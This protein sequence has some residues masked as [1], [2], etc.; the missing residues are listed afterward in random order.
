M[1]KRVFWF[2][3]IMPVRVKAVQFHEKEFAKYEPEVTRS[4]Y[5]ARSVSTPTG[6]VANAEFIFLGT[7]DKQ[8]PVE[9]GD[10][11]VFIHEKVFPGYFVPDRPEH[12]MVMRDDEFRMYF[13]NEEEEPEEETV[14]PETD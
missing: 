10:W 8:W 9:D 2:D 13:G 14:E 1:K 6:D 5:P 3:Q 12:S 7:D 11:I 4:P